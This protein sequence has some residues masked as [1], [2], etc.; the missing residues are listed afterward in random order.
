[1]DDDDCGEDGLHQVRSK[2]FE[3]EHEAFK[4]TLWHG[5]EPDRFELELES[6][7]TPINMNKEVALALAYALMSMASE[8]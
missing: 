7:R 2:T 6:N 1:M 8:M 5:P 4:L 3:T